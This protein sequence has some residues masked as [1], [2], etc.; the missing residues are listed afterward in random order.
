MC[1]ENVRNNAM[2]SMDRITIGAGRASGSS[3]PSSM[4]GPRSSLP[5]G[6]PVSRLSQ[7]TNPFPRN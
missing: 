1:L 2:L 5:S 3:P 6:E 7:I 4:Y